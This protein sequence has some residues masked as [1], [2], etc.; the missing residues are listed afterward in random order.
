MKGLMDYR[1]DK[2]GVYK[3]REWRGVKDTAYDYYRWLINWKDL[4][5]FVGSHPIQNMK[6]VFRYRWMTTYLATPAF[7]DRAVSGQRGAE[8]RVGHEH[9]N[10]IVK[11]LT[12][13]LGTL[14]VADQ[15]I[16]GKKALSDKIVYCDELI[17]PL[18]FAGFKNLKVL[19][20][21]LAP[22][23]IASMV[24]QNFTP[25]YLDAIEAYGVPADV[26]PL[27]SGEAGLAVEDDYP[28]VGTCFISCNM[29][30][31]GSIMTSSIQERRFNMPTHVLAIPLRYDDENV[32]QYAVEELRSMIAFIEEQTGEKFDWQ[33]LYKAVETYNE[34]TRHSLI[35]WDFNK[36]DKP[37]VTG[38]NLW[39]YRVYTFQ[40]GM[41]NPDF[42]KTDKKVRKIIE[43]NYKQGKSAPEKIRHRAVI[44]SCPANYYTDFPTWLENCWGISALMDMESA[45]STIL[46]D[47]SSQESILGG[48]A[49]TYQGAVMR[50]HTKGGYEHALDYLWETVEEYGADMVI[51]YDQISCKGM[52]GLVGLFKDQ[53]RKRGIKMLWVAQDLMDPRT[54]SRAQMRE[55]VNTYMTTVMDEEPLDPSLLKFDD[56]E[57]W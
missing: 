43:K 54:I 40:V 22:L 8:L 18:I 42:L 50:R 25:H 38:G 4:I 46:I 9:Y 33:A 56:S 36:S 2:T 19:P 28:K 6:A 45:T 47:E 20:A 3:R 55:A 52:D 51:I 41:G 32:Q 31:D 39:L 26:C 24:N 16:G 44:W 37:Q 10:R 14:F 5:K 1:Y 15:N 21:Q 35:K 27:P 30:C 53:A 57:S 7:V 11:H 17:P 12:G 29:P 49:K 34:Q 48:I 13:L 23:F